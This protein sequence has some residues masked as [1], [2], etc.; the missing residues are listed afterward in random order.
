MSK[1]VKPKQRIGQKSSPKKKI[2]TWSILL[3]ACTGGVF[4]AYHYGTT[5]TKVEVP[6]VKARK[7]EFVISVRTRGEV[8]SVRAE[9]LAAPQVPNPRIVKLAESGKPI[10]AGE[11]VCEF[12]AAQQEQTYLEKDTSVRTADSEIVQLKATQKITR[13]MDNMNLMTSGYNV[14]RAKLE[15]SKAAVVSDIE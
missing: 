5:T 6:V 2:L 13:E 3:F 10:K 7:A 11:V 15:A 8:R 12:D 4:A 9:I 14:E 1:D